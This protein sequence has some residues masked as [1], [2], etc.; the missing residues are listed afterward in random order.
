MSEPLRIKSARDAF[1]LELGPPEQ[2]GREGWFPVVLGGGP[3]VA[4]VLVYDLRLDQVARFF[5]SMAAESTGWN[6]EKSWE[7]LS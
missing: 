7:S 5:E 3:A 6:G 2:E 4:Q 1:E